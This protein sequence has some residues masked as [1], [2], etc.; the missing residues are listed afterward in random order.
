MIVAR[1]VPTLDRVSCHHELV[2]SQ[3]RF[4]TETIHNGAG[5]LIP[6]VNGTS[7]ATLIGSYE[8]ARGYYPA[9]GYG[10]LVPEHFN[11][12]DLSRYYLGAEA[13]QWPKLGEAW[14]LGCDCGEVGC[15]PLAARI[16]VDGTTVTWS[17]FQQ[18]HRPDW[19]YSAFGPFKFDRQQYEK[20]VHI[21]M[22]RLKDANKPFS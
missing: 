5:S 3:L 19:D 21:G 13:S 4:R 16:T 12:G 14:L 10:G 18:P 1:E 9:G 22:A 20:A 11:F 7:L 15:W 2:I 17:T 8:S 6:E